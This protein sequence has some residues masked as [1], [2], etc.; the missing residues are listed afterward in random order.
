[1]ETFSLMES[2]ELRGNFKEN[3]FYSYV[4]QSYI[5]LPIKVMM[6]SSRGMHSALRIKSIVQQFGFILLNFVFKN[7]KVQLHFGPGFSAY[8][9]EQDIKSI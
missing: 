4:S 2:E 6:C 9:S 8:I 1:M 7:I 3:A 5:H